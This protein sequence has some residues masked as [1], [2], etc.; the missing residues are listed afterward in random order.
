MSTLRHQALSVVSTSDA[1]VK[2]SSALAADRLLP[3]GSACSIDEPEGIPGRPSRPA[4][5]SPAEV[6]RPS[7]AKPEGIAA[8]IHALAHIE[9]NAI[10]LAA[11]AC[12]RFEGMPDDFYRDWTRV[13]VEE[14]RHFDLL[15]RHLA[16]LGHGYGDF[17]AHKALWEMAERTR[18][19]V[20]GRMALVPRTL[21]AR[22]LDASP[23]V[24]H[25]LASSGDRG[26]AVIVD[27]ILADEIGHVEIGNRWYRWLCM[28]RGVDPF[29]TY[30]VLA[31]RHGAP[32]LTG[33]FNFDARRKAGFDEAELQALTVMAR[34]EPRR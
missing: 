28:Q 3:A 31:E 19:D 30:A 34:P 15:T 2:A 29:A 33:P 13:M 14:A 22:G 16:K 11:D 27:R 1:A 26:G 25:R 23:A 9:L 8:L 21:E 6:P 5:V 10:D 18:G 20:L 12:W 7:L 4:L 32:R 24:R 17:P